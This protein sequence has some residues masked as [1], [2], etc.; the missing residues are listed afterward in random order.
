LRA[1]AIDGWGQKLQSVAASLALLLITG[2]LVIGHQRM[3]EMSVGAFRRDRRVSL[4]P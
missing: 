4:T 3:T 2:F 1:A